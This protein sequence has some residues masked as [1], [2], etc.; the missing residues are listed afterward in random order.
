[1][2]GR[3]LV[4][5][6]CKKVH[7]CSDLS[8]GT[9]L[10]CGGC[11]WAVTVPALPGTRPVLLRKPEAPP[12]SR[13]AERAVRIRDLIDEGAEQKHLLRTHLVEA[14]LAEVAELVRLW[15]WMGEIVAGARKR[16]K[17]STSDEAELSDTEAGIA[18]MY[19]SVL[20][21]LEDPRTPGHL[22]VDLAQAKVNLTKLLAM[23]DAEYL[24]FQ[25]EW[26]GGLRLLNDYL[27]FLEAGRQQLAKQTWLQYYWAKFFQNRVAGGIAL[28]A[29]IAL[30]AF[31]GVTVYRA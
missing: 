11:G 8:P 10:K 29:A 3:D 9:V 31:V 6:K 14:R 22:V 23:S 7:D 20:K 2:P 26:E 24:T 19:V 1:M 16:G 27:R 28:V 21:R 30:G 18:R 25:R 15:T 5:P 13:E 17:A 4:C 12:P